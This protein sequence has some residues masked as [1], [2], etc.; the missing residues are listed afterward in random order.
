MD[1][2]N[3]HHLGIYI[4]KYNICLLY[5]VEIT[6]VKKSRQIQPHSKQFRL[7]SIRLYLVM[8]VRFGLLG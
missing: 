1:L 5:E 7:G 6:C 2:H 4:I 3:W 8:F